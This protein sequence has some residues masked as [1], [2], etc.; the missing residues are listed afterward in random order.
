MK[1]VRLAQI[2]LGA[3]GKNI[4]KTLRALSGC[5]LAYT[6]TEDWRELLDKKDIDGAVIATPPATH[7]EIAIAFLQR[8]VPVFIEKPDRK[9]VV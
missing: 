6:A 3:W 8:G 1:T 5:E 2:G 7:A 9:S 4:E